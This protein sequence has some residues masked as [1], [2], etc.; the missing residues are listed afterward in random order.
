MRHDEH[1][2]DKHEARAFD[3][4]RY[5]LLEDDESVLVQHLLGF[6]NHVFCTG[7]VEPLVLVG[8]VFADVQDVTLCL[9][10]GHAPCFLLGC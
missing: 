1:S 6:A 8:R 9:K 7:V 2:L 5:F 4:S 10:Q 3:L